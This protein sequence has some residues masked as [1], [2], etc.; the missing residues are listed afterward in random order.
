MKQ[1]ISYTLCLVLLSTANASFA[2]NETKDSE[3]PKSI[4]IIDAAPSTGVKKAVRRNLDEICFEGGVGPVF[5]TGGDD[6]P[7]EAGLGINIG[8]IAPKPKNHFAI[9]YLLDLDYC[10]AP[11]KSWYARSVGTTTANIASLSPGVNMDLGIVVSG[12]LI[13]KHKLA[14]IIG[15]ELMFQSMYLSSIKLNAGD[16][17]GRDDLFLS[18]APGIKASAFVGDKLIV[19]IE[20]SHCLKSEV[21]YDDLSYGSHSFTT[22]INVRLLRAGVG[23]RF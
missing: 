23:F 14:V 11:S 4:Y 15:P 3:K 8:F 1:I 6:A 5:F 19:T 22:P 2:Q 13:N 12:I 17:N 7:F 10:L 16:P 21:S 18:F 20:Y 9:E